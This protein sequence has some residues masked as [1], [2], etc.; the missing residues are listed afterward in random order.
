MQERATHRRLMG[1]TT[2]IISSMANTMP[3]IGVLNVAAMPPPAPAAM[4][5]ARCRVGMEMI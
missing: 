5:M 2:G 3:P 1:L 4:S